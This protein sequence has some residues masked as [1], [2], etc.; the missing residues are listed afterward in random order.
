MAGKENKIILWFEELTKDDIPYVGGKC[1][2][3]GELTRAGAPTP[4]GFAVTAY[5]Y[6]IFIEKTGLKD[7][8]NS[9]LDNIDEYDINK[10]EDTS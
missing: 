10:L 7:K 8:I 1:A 2:N 9:I 3:L 5:A 6:K 4:K